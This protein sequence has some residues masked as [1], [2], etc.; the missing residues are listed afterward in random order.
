MKAAKLANSARLQRALRYLQ[1]VKRPVTPL[2][3]VLEARVV[4]VSSVISELRRN[5]A[6]IHCEKKYENGAFRWYYTLLKS[7]E[8]W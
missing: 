7:P 2:E 1:K 8:G 3:M 6:D 4:S 5:G